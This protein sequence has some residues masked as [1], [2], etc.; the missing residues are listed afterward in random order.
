MA[1]VK[2]DFKVTASEA[3][4]YFI[5]VDDNDLVMINGGATPAP[6]LTAGEEHLLIWRM[7]GNP[8]DSVSIVGTVG[9]REVVNVKESKIPGGKTK[10]AGYK[11]FTP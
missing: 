9:T 4:Q 10:G 11:R 6:M 1:K 2:V 5:G 7:F 8:G 3:C